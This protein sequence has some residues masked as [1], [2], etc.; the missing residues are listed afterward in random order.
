VGQRWVETTLA[1]KLGG[2]RL[3][4]KYDLILADENA[5]LTIFDW[6]TSQKA[7]RKEGL[8]ARI[9]TRLYRLVLLQASSTLFSA[10]VISPDQISMNYWF[11]TLPQALISLPYSQ[12]AYEQDLAD[13]TDLIEKICKADTGDFQRTAVLSHCRFC[14]YRSHCDRGVEAGSLD[15]FDVLDL[16]PEEGGAWIDFE[17]LPEIEF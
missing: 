15:D 11:A 9:Q 3:V 4:A 1:T 5:G 7:P 8:L 12:T 2:Q 16:E 17:D 10:P 14:V 13:L 6:K